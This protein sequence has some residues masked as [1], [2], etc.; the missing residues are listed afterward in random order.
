M[1]TVESLKSDKPRL[2]NEGAS[3]LTGYAGRNYFKLVAI[4]FATLVIYTIATYSKRPTEITLAGWFSIF[5]AGLPIILWVRG[6][7]PGLPVYPL[8]SLCYLITYGLQFLLNT[9]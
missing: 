4:L 5:A 3:R 7:V 9:E 8:F 1:Q 2:I 6:F